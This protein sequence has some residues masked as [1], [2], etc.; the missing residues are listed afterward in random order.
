[1]DSPLNIPKRPEIRIYKFGNFYL[2]TSERKLLKDTEL[3]DVP[4]RAFD[5]LRMLCEY[6]GEAVSKDQILEEVWDGSFVEEGNLT[7]YVSKL[8]KLLGASKSDPFIETVSGVGYRFV[9]KVSTVSEREWKKQLAGLSRHTDEKVRANSVAVMPLT[10]ENGDR[11]IEYLADGLTE[12]LINNLS[13]IPNFRT[14]SRNTVFQYKDTDVD[15]LET[16]RELEV[17]HILSGRIR[18]INDS[19]VIGVELTRISDATQ[20][21]GSQVNQPFEDIFNTQDRI[22][23]TLTNNLK[24]KLQEVANESV[25][26]NITNNSESY[27][28]YLKGQYFHN[29]RSINNIDKAINC[30][31]QSIN[32][33]P[34]NAYSYLELAN[35]YMVRYFY[36]KLSHAE[37][38]DLVSSILNKTF[39]LNP[40][41]PKYYVVQGIF[42]MSLE[43]E[44]EKAED[45]F[46]QAILLNPNL[47]EARFYYSKLLCFTGRFSEGFNEIKKMIQLDPISLQTNKSISRIYL[48]MEQYDNAI[49]LLKEC[50]D[51]SP[52]DYETLLLMGSNLTELERYDEAIEYFERAIN[53]QF[54]YEALS[55]IAYANIKAGK[56]KDGRKLLEKLTA[57]SKTSYIP[58]NYFAIIFSALGEIDKVFKFL[59]QAYEHKNS[60]L[61][62]L[63]IDPRYKIIRNDPRFNEL[64][65]KIGLPVSK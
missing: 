5:I 21:W 38:V 4:A 46:R 30:F 56:L 13:H 43:F 22:S 6:Q 36:E 28:L 12:S 59:Y 15:I 10:N 47:V 17:A 58:P 57:D 32:H 62:S 33:D 50:L 18:I 1:M 3:I 9:S 48:M 11:E 45:N 63:K 34:T 7:V 31:N 19:L 16:G 35:C 14:I 51:L 61:T 64:L 54:H 2:N 24:A 39:E 26:Q 23:H 53:E 27:R 25:I 52:N 40:D 41:I 49:W 44:L 42:N 65:I 20:I 37:A 60:N 8:R 29:Q 55:M